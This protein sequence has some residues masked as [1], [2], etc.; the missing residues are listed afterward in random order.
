MVGI[1]VSETPPALASAM[2]ASRSFNV[3]PGLLA[4]RLI[5]FVDPIWLTLPLHHGRYVPVVAGSGELPPLLTISQV[6]ELWVVS[7]S[8]PYD[9]R[10]ELP[11]LVLP[12]VAGGVHCWDRDLVQAWLE[13][14][15][16]PDHAPKK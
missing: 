6:A 7:F 15:T 5:D 12:P 10:F 13:Q 4:F 11:G 1:A 8:E 16:P 3:M 14:Q 9:R 2:N